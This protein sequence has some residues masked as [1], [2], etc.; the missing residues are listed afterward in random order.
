MAPAPSGVDGDALLTAS[1]LHGRNPGRRSGA[2]QELSARHRARATGVIRGMPSNDTTHSRRL[3]SWLPIAEAH[4]AHQQRCLR[5]RLAPTIGA[6]LTP[7]LALGPN[8]AAVS[9]GGTF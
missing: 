8:L 2:M 9:L 4:A 7:G 1:S 5:R 3:F 6:T